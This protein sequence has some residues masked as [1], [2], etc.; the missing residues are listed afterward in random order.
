[1]KPYYEENGIKIFCRDCMDAMKEMP[2]KAFEL[3]IV[4]PPYGININNN[5]GRRK[6]DKASDYKKVKWDDKPPSAEYFKELFRVSKNQIVW[7]AN[8][9]T[10]PPTKCFIVWRKPQISEQVSFS[11][12]EYA[13][14]SFDA[15]SKEWIG[16]SAEDDRI[17][18][19][20]KPVALYKWL[21][22]NYAKKG[23]RILDTHLGSGSSAIAAYDMGFELTGYEIDKDY[24]E[25]ATE[26]IKRHMSQGVLPLETPQVHNSTLPLDIKCEIEENE[27]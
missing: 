18:P 19:T 1:M 10:M 24:F 25:A 3:A 17:H 16:M 8:Y 22:K 27:A 21:L 9:F 12:C 15:T 6:G 4:D 2:D 13:W 5:M 23:D 26:R 11:M 14:A 20:Q 7:G